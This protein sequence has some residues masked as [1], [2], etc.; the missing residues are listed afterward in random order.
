MTQVNLDKE[1]KSATRAMKMG[2]LYR[3]QIK[4]YKD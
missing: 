4:K 2:L 3:K 1:V